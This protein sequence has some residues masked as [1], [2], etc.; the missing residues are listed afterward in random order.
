MHQLGYPWNSFLAWEV[1]WYNHIPKEIYPYTLS[2]FLFS[3]GVLPL[4]FLPIIIGWIKH[5]TRNELFLFCMVGIP[6]CLYM[7]ASKR[8]IPIPKI[9]FA[10][11]APYV[12]G[13]VFAVRGIA[14]IDR[15]LRPQRFLRTAVMICIY[16]LVLLN[17]VSGIVF[18]WIPLTKSVSYDSI[19]HLSA[20]HSDMIT[21]VNAIIPPYSRVMVPYGIGTILPAFTKQHVFVG[22]MVNTSDVWN[23]YANSQQFYSGAMTPKD[24]RDLLRSFDIT[25]VIWEY[26]QA[27]ESYQS[28]L[29]PISQSGMWIYQ[30]VV[31]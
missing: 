21:A 30:V 17:A 6:I 22:H 29:T 24:A 10:F 28:F 16:S 9:R 3:F 14:L 20:S 5:R 23:K 27:P 31:P 4:F 15:I 12:F 26:G 7:L 1:A 11:V 8:L 18:Y 25:H 2:V 19:V 13:T